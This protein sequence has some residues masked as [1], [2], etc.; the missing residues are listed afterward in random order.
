MSRIIDQ[1]RNEHVRHESHVMDLINMANANPHARDFI[2]RGLH[3]L[4]HLGKLLRMWH[5]VK[6][7][8][9]NFPYT[10]GSATLEDTEVWVAHAMIE[11]QDYCNRHFEEFGDVLMRLP[12][13][14]VDPLEYRYEF[15]NNAYDGYDVQGRLAIVVRGDAG[16]QQNSCIKLSSNWFCCTAYC[17]LTQLGEPSPFDLPSFVQVG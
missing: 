5:P 16:N 17:Y 8:P 3:M 14:N 15:G 10:V 11:L 1:L 9:E 7:G 2:V 6:D 12:I 4:L 13:V